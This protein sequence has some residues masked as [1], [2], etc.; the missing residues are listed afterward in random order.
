V[1]GIDRL[2]SVYI[3]ALQSTLTFL[4]SHG[5]DEWALQICVRVM[6]SGF[7]D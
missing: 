4:V 5:C 6:Q 3:H 7:D 1:A 2:Q